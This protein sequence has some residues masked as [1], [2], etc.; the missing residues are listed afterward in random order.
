MESTIA[1]KFEVM[2]KLCILNSRM[3][4]FFDIWFL[5]RRFNFSGHTLQK[6]VRATFVTRS[7]SLPSVPVVFTF[8]FS[9]DPIKEAQ[10]KVFVRKNR[11]VNIP[12]GFQQIVA[13]IAAFL[14]P[15][16]EN[17]AGNIPFT[18]SWKAPGPWKY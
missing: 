12:K 6:A 13:D 3:K 18:P 9:G 15:V 8:D 14:G 7:T 5:T 10:W 11:L 16:V 2:V 1:E 17:L 4:D